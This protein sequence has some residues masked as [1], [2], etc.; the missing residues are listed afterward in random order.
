MLYVKLNHVGVL[1]KLFGLMKQASLQKMN[2]LCLFALVL[3]KITLGSLRVT[4]KEQ[5]P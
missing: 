5:L 3:E 2:V 4:P 1:T